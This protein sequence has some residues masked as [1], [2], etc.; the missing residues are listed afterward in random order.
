MNEIPYFIAGLINAGCGYIFI[1]GNIDLSLIIFAIPLSL[2][3][4]N[5]ILLF[6]IPDGEVDIHGEKR[7]FI[8]TYRR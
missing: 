2:R 4:L 1:T 8:V 7:N 6:E 5:V 3:L